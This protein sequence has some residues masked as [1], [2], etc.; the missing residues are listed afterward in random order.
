[1][2]VAVSS[3]SGGTAGIAT[4][5]NRAAVPLRG[6]GAGRLLAGR[7]LSAPYDAVNAVGPADERL[8]KAPGVSAR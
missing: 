5:D 3:R 8:T 6:S 2:L 1:V 4:W 7:D